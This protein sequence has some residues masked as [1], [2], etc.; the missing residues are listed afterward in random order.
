M[1]SH[2]RRLNQI[3]RLSYR[4]ILIALFASVLL[5]GDWIY[6]MS[7]GK[8]G[9]IL[10]TQ[11]SIDVNIID[12][13]DYIENRGIVTVEFGSPSFELQSHFTATDVDGNLVFRRTTF[14]L[15]ERYSTPPWADTRTSKFEWAER[16]LTGLS[17]THYKDL[18]Q[19]FLTLARQLSEQQ[20]PEV[21]AQLISTINDTTSDKLNW[22]GITHNI[23]AISLLI[24]VALGS[25][26][27]VYLFNKSRG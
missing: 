4:C 10:L 11:S 9:G 18:P 14:W 19:D 21:K 13:F 1:E 3:R 23:C 16:T 8:G 7:T 25:I 5:I 24:V 27:F 2:T 17:P 20:E 15:V 12:V 26:A 6:L 22:F